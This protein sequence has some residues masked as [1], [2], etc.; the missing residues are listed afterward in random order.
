[1]KKQILRPDAIRNSI[2]TSLHVMHEKFIILILVQYYISC[3]SKLLLYFIMF[4]RLLLLFIPSIIK[5]YKNSYMSTM[6]W[7]TSCGLK[8]K[9]V[10]CCWKFC[11]NND[12]VSQYNLLLIVIFTYFISRISVPILHKHTQFLPASHCTY[13]H[14]HIHTREHEESRTK[15]TL[16]GRF[17]WRLNLRAVKMFEE[18]QKVNF[19]DRFKVYNKCK[20]L[21]GLLRWMLHFNDK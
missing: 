15:C 13:T 8:T 10:H 12:R 4:F 5:G 1:M 19:I 2:A 11:N 14:K 16:K 3:V 20:C 9:L 7:A 17:A 18:S 21:I 6:K